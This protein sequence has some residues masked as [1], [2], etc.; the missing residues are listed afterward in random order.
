MNNKLQ[1]L[2]THW[3]RYWWPTV[4]DPAL[5]RQQL[6][7]FYATRSDYHDMTAGGD[8]LGHPHVRLFLDTLPNGC[9]A[10][11]FGCGGGVVLSGTARQAR[12][13]IGLDIAPLALEK[14]Q[15]RM[16]PA[17][18]WVVAQ[19][20]VT[21]APVATDS[22]DVVYSF[23]V[24][25]HVWDPEAMLR[26]MIRVA[27]PGGLLFLTTPN[28][29][30]LDLHLAK[31]QLVRVLD[32]LGAGLAGVRS[33]FARRS[34]HN[35]EP[36]LDVAAVYPDCDMISTFFPARL[37]RF[38]EENGCRVERLE[39]FFFQGTKAKDTGECNRY[40]RLDRHWFYRNFGD[41]ILLLARKNQ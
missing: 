19:A 41:H 25:E 20:D 40:A 21:A 37:R 13:V 16:S 35:M 7:R 22:A 3:G 5:T 1:K 17:S 27:R 29:L 34:F 4:R 38:M 2:L 36:D 31:H 8:K 14:I 11:E 9:V 28:G 30:S 6:A 32:H 26:E 18:R 24:I 33:R 23:E 10:V 15:Q 39:T 12:V